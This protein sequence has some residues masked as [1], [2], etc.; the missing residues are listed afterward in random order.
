MPF[1]LGVVW[2]LL[3]TDVLQGLEYRDA[4]VRGRR[5]A[6]PTPSCARAST[7]SA[8]SFRNRPHKGKKWGTLA[9]HLTT[10]Y[11][12]AALREVFR[13][14]DAIEVDRLQRE[15]DRQDHRRVLSADRRG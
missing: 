4:A 15:A 9:W 13:K 6:R 12:V 14:F 2:A 8:T 7:I 11:F 3:C 1:T 5:G 10:D